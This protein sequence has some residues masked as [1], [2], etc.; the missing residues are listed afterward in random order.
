MDIIAQA[1][2]V[3]RQGGYRTRVLTG[4]P[5]A[6]LSFE[7][8]VIVGF[9]RA[10]GSAAELLAGWQSAERADLSRHA[11]QLK[12]A[13]RKAWNIYSIFLTEAPGSSAELRE[14]DAIE[15][16][17]AATRKIARAGIST[18]TELERTLLPV[19]P[20]R[21]TTTLTGI[22]DHSAKLR[23]HL[24]FLPSEVA[25]AILSGASSAEILRRAAGTR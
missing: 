6:L 4:T 14:I 9:L 25:N 8:D 3:L 23:S 18:I 19:L 1:D 7:D 16:D 13:P 17:F 20:L 2:N 5:I 12:A 15:E 10:F 21:T 11:T 24:A 22:S